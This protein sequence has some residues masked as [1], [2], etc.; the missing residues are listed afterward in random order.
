MV[1][2]AFSEMGD[3]MIYCTDWIVYLGFICE[4]TL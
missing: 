2:L 4:G 1:V 3:Y